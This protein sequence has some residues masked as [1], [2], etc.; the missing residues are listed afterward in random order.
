M[1]LS[2]S[3]QP[4]SS[5]LCF[6]FWTHL[7]VETFYWFFLVRERDACGF[8]H[9]VPSLHQR[10]ETNAHLAGR[11]QT[12]STAATFQFFLSVSALTHCLCFHCCTCL[13]VDRPPVGLFVRQPP[14]D[15]FYFIDIL[16]AHCWL[17]LFGVETRR[18]STW[19]T[20][21]LKKPSMLLFSFLTGSKQPV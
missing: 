20:A 11:L 7:S 19:D 13:A 3:P 4:H 8:V 5:C 21:E 1:F 2:P 14:F 18:K 10:K 17:Y 9:T 12:Q 16:A 15:L 6:C